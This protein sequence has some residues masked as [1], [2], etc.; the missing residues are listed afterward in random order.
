MVKNKNVENANH[1]E[2]VAIVRKYQKKEAVPFTVVA[3]ACDPLNPDRGEKSE[4]SYGF[5][6]STGGL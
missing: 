3:A 4:I 2:V 6:F 5:S 1:D